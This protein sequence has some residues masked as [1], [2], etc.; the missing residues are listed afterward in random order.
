MTSQLADQTV[1]AI[2][3]Y[4]QLVESLRASEEKF[5]TLFQLS[6][7]P[8]TITAIADGAF[9]DVNQAF[10]RVSGYSR[11]EAIG[12]SSLK[13]GLFANPADRIALAERI[14]SLG[15]VTADPIVY[16]TKQGALLNSLTSASVVTIGGQSYFIAGIT[17]ITALKPRRPSTSST[18]AWPHSWKILTAVFGR[19]TATI[20]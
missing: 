6:P 19:S 11:E 3:E 1:S 13:L 17:D 12:S 10:E 8:M 2:G 14:Q 5:A 4:Q 18:P 7:I 20:A 9:R 15:L 16:R